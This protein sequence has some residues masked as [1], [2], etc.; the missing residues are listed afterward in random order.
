[1]PQALVREIPVKITIP[2]VV[3]KKRKLKT[4]EISKPYSIQSIR[5]KRE[6]EKE[7]YIT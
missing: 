4:R 1:M 6:I 7:S 3:E 2:R 5:S